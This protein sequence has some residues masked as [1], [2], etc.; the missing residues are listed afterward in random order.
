M[1]GVYGEPEAD[2]DAGIDRRTDF[3]GSKS[4]A[5]FS[6]KCGSG[7]SVTVESHRNP[8]RRRGSAN[9]SGNSDWLRSG[10]SCLYSG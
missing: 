1:S 6:V 2:T 7:V 5:G 3:K 8:F 4:K 9:P 10:G